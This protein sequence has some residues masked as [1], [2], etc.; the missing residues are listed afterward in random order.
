[1]A[2]D[3]LL[4]PGLFGAETI[5]SSKWEAEN[6]IVTGEKENLVKYLNY[7]KTLYSIGGNGS[8]IFTMADAEVEHNF[9]PLLKLYTINSGRDNLAE[10]LYSE[11]LNK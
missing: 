1:M 6:V 8:K 5:L 4:I 7:F 11:I 3:M 10:Y 2:R 9:A